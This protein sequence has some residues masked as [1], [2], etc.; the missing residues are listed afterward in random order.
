MI[1]DNVLVITLYFIHKCAKFFTLFLVYVDDLLIA[2]N[3][4]DI[5]T[6]TKQLLQKHF[7]IKYLGPL[8]YF[9]GLEIARKNNGI[10]INQRKYTLDILS[11]TGLLACKPS[12]TP[13]ARDTRLSTNKGNPMTDPTKFIRLVGQ[14]IYLLNT[15]PDIE[16]VFQQLS[17]HTHSPTDIH[18]ETALCVLRYLKAAPAQGLFFPSTQ[19]I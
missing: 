10:N 13:M 11:T 3:N 17:Q 9:L 15:R 14:L 19:P 1:S 7:H 16:Y 2:G 4:L 8:K 6:Q 5:I 12:S 18:Y